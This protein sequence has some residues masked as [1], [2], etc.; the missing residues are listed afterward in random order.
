[1]QKG[2]PE[3]PL[4]SQKCLKSRHQAP[5]RDGGYRGTLL[6]CLLSSTPGLGPAH[7]PC[8]HPET[9]F[10]FPQRNLSLPPAWAFASPK[11]PTL[12]FSVPAHTG[13]GGKVSPC[14]KQV[15]LNSHRESFPIGGLPCPSK[16]G[17][18]WVMMAGSSVVPYSSIIHENTCC[19]AKRAQVQGDEVSQGPSLL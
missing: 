14:F 2:T 9:S 4:G 7:L 15:T 3:F 16:D 19:K 8:F 1:M 6:S 17:Q 5:D 18:R 10:P 11:L 12:L 13:L